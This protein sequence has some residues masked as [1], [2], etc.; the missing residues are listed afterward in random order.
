MRTNGSRRIPGLIHLHGRQCHRQ[1]SSCGTATVGIAIGSP[2]LALTSAAQGSHRHQQPKVGPAIRS[3]RLAL[4]SAVAAAAVATV[5]TATAA[6]AAA[7]RRAR[8]GRPIS[9]AHHAPDTPS[10]VFSEYLSCFPTV[11]AVSPWERSTH[12]VVSRPS[13]P[14]GPRAW[15]RP[16]DTPT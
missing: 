7:V 5:A 8:V 16:V 14:T 11:C 12:F 9:S 10:R 13:T 2:G 3:P 4:P 1:P 15:M 6:A